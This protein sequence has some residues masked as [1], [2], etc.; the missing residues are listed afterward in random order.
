VLSIA[1]I[2]FI[3]F[4][5]LFSFLFSTPYILKGIYAIQSLEA[6]M[7][8]MDPLFLLSYTNVIYIGFCFVFIDSKNELKL[9]TIYMPNMSDKDSRHPLQFLMEMF[10][11]TNQVTVYSQ[12]SKL[13]DINYHRS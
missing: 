1:T 13:H 6:V 11:T 4:I 9:I 8:T 7:P 10:I 5:L 2:F 3:V 12:D